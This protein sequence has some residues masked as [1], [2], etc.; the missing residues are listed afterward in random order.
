MKTD[1]YIVL[2]KDQNKT[3]KKTVEK[4]FQLKLTSSE[5]LSSENKSYDI[6]D[7][8]NGVLYKNLNVLVADQLDEEQLMQAMKDEDNPVLYYEKEKTFYVESS[9]SLVKDLQASFSEIQQ[10]LLELEK[11]LKAKPKNAISKALS[12]EWGLLS[13][14]L[15]K[16]QLTGKGVDV[17]I[18]D[19]GFDIGHPDFVG[20]TIEGK[21][22]VEG[23]P[24][25]TDIKGHGTHCAGTATGN[26]RSDTGKRYGIAKNANLKIAKV[27]AHDGSGKSSS[28]V[29]AIDWAI[30]KKYRI[31]S[32]SLS[33]PVALNEPPSPI[34]EMIGQK[35][36]DNNCLVIA[37]A[38]NDSQRPALPQPVSA[39]A[40]VVS[41]LAVAA[42]DN[43]NRVASFSNGGLN[44]ASG[45][46]VNLCAPGVDVLSAYP[47]VYGNPPYVL[48]N[49][50]SMATPHVAGVAAL[51]MEKYPH[52]SAVEIWKLLEQNAR[53]LNDLKYR[54]V[55]NGL[56][57]IINEL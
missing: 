18:M 31:I 40:N 54:D 1:K 8:K 13:I 41:I 10:K 50:T 26:V 35:A 42:M 23:E 5:F 7:D 11:T 57:Q 55:G 6:I 32:M 20:R 56:V 29:D 16:S 43:Q 45:G 17:C 34:F 53:K 27:L 37:A 47:V 3:T 21:S 4:E 48:K 28:I 46:A 12:Y 44:A 22:F 38:G 30:T 52:L 51:Y 49:G 25:D 19:T 2:L 39:P 14:G 15:D 36:L 9:L 24:W 33:A